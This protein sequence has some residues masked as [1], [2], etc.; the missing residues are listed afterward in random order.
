MSKVINQLI[1]LNV[2]VKLYQW[3]TI[4]HK[5][6]KISEE[7]YKD[8][9]RLSDEFVELYIKTY[10][11]RSIQAPF[12]TIKLAN[13]TDRCMMQYIKKVREFIKNELV[14]YIDEDVDTELV[15]ISDELCVALSVTLSGF[16]IHGINK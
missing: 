7:S 14:K 9:T 10:G 12:S 3:N 13:L 8:I 5:I 4:P 1:H 2:Q 15:K 11:R 16:I 6:Y